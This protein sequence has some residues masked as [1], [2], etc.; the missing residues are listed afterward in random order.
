MRPRRTA[1]IALL[2]LLVT[3]GV[4]RP[5][6]ADLTAFVGNNASPSNRLVR[7]VAVGLS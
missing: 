3:L 4:V 7:G 2:V 6:R 1:T 5:A